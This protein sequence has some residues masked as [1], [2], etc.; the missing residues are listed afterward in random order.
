MLTALVDSAEL[1][2]GAMD[3]NASSI[4]LPKPVDLTLLLHVLHKAI[5]DAEGA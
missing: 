1:S 2:E 5:K 3:Q 4:I